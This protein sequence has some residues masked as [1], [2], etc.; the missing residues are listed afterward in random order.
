VGTLTILTTH[1]NPSNSNLKTDIPI[2][3]QPDYH[4]SASAHPII[5][6]ESGLESPETLT[7]R[8]EEEAAARANGGPGRSESPPG[9]L[10]LGGSFGGAGGLGGAGLGL[11]L[12]MA[13][14]KAQPPQMHGMFSFHLELGLVLRWMG[15]WLVW[16]AWRVQGWNLEVEAALYHW[17][18]PVWQPCMRSARQ[19]P[20]TPDGTMIG[21]N[22]IAH[23]SRATST[24]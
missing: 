9:T 6:G 20:G 24:C 10:G 14:Y 7:I 11:S 23:I 8:L 12:P 16:S 1:S 2:L 5:V 17:V 4:P 21:P 18:T 19:G 3:I 22:S 15:V 13:A